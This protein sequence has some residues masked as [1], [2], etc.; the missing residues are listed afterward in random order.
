MS[1]HSEISAVNTSASNELALYQVAKEAIS[2]GVAH[3]RAENLW[4]TLDQRHGW[5]L[6]T[7]RDDGIGFDPLEPK[8][9]HFGIH[10]MRER[11]VASGGETYID[12]TPGAGCTVSVRLRDH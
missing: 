5:I 7:I 1:I 11:V 9:G 4:L 8:G 6:M 12:S 10:I 2:N 3:S